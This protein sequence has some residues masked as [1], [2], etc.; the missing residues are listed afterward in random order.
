MMLQLGSLVLGNVHSEFNLSLQGHC[1]GHFKVIVWTNGSDKI[2]P[3]G[4]FVDD[5]FHT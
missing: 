4:V 5:A 2:L 3:F 1:E